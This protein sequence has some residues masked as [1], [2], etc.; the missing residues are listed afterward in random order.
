M[1]SDYGD[2]NLLLVDFKI[3]KKYSILSVLLLMENFRL[4]L[5]K[6]LNTNVLNN[7]DILFVYYHLI[8]P[9]YLMYFA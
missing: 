3:D 7:V 5:W 9:T 1:E 6:Q 4:P 8:L 2:L